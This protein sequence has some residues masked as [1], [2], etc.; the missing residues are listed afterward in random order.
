MCKMN[1]LG[2]EMHTT[3][4]CENLKLSEYRRHFLDLIDRISP[5]FLKLDKE[6]QFYYIM[7]CIDD[8]ITLPF[9]MYLDKIYRTMK[10]T[11]VVN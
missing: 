8:N 5:Q 7:Q 4:F 9:A 2:S 6:Q 11:N 3:M 10:A 1:E